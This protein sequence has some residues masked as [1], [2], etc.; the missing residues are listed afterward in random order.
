MSQK[1]HSI[2]QQFRNKKI[3]AAGGLVAGYCVYSYNQNHRMRKIDGK[4]IYHSLLKYQDNKERN[5]MIHN[6]K[7]RDQHIKEIETTQYD[8]LIIGNKKT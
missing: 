4:N 2:F 1:L 6:L 5:T 8:T 3:L 7:T